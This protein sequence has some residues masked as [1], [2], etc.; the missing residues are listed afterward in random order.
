MS[1]INY[2]VLKSLAKEQRCRVA[3]LIALAPQNDPF[4]TGSPGE[5]EKANWFADL[6]HQFNYA[7]G[8]HLR[9]VHYQLI[10][11]PDPRKADGSRYQNTE[12]DWN[13]LLNA[14]KYA[15]YLGLVNPAAFEDRRNPD[16]LLIASYYN[17]APPGY[18]LDTYQL[19]EIEFP[20]WP[21]LPGFDI[22]G[23]DVNLQP[24]HLE[25]WVEKTTM[26]DVLRPLC[27]RYHA[28]LVTGAGEMSITSVLD[29]IKRIEEAER[30]ARIFYVSDFDPAGYG[31]PISVA[32]KIEFLVD[33]LDLDMDIRLEPVALT[34]DQARDYSLPRTPIKDTELRKGNFEDIHGEGAVELDALEALYPGALREIVQVNCDRYYDH[35]IED[36]L[37]EGRRNLR[38]TL[39]ETVAE[40]IRATLDD[41]PEWDDLEERFNQAVDEFRETIDPIQQDL[42]EFM[43]VL[44]DRLSEITYDVIDPEEFFPEEVKQAEEDDS[45]LFDSNRSY[46]EQ[47]LAYKMQRMGGNGR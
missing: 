32:R 9:R 7:S 30:P 6:W 12:N 28:N 44:T 41:H 35:E 31:M 4:Y 43:E 47:L 8:V 25:I 3:D 18:E 26:N 19:G 16:P 42:S 23:F 39:D 10:S 29:L 37:R 2:A 33:Q 1:R 11:Q 46:G 40:T 20:T 21:A 27:Y 45:V 36:H 34:R 14:G 38:D 5:V 13:Y 15:R 24:Y 17:D 22:R